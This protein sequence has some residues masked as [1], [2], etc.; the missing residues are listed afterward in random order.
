MPSPA[1]TR[2]APAKLNLFL[3]I[4][5]RRADGYHELQTLFQLLDYGDELSFD[6]LPNGDLSLHAEGP[7]ASAMPLDDNLILQAA[8]L[9]RQEA[10]DPM[11]G[12]AISVGKRLP[13]GAGLGGGS[14]DAAATLLALNEL[15]QLDLPEAR[16]CELGVKLGADVPVFLRGRSAWA[17]GVGEILTP[18]ELPNAFFLVV[19]PPCFVSTKEV[20][21]QENLTRN[22]PAIKMADFLAGRSRNDCEAVTRALYPA[23]AEALDWLAQFTEAR[24][25]GTGASVFARCESRAE[26]EQLLARLPE[27]LTGFVAQGVNTLRG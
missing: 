21:S 9:L 20:F 8:E 15:W 7:T 19:T 6:P 25:T 4:T 22:S 24:M 13:A 10:M 18:V 16:L 14:S 3:H 5:G 1:L 12:A 2:L 23:V 17:E 11:L 27:P 26:A